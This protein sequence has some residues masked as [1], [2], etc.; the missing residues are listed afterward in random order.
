MCKLRVFTENHQRYHLIAWQHRSRLLSEV[1]NKLWPGQVSKLE[2][3]RITHHKLMGTHRFLAVEHPWDMILQPSDYIHQAQPGAY[4]K[5][6]DVFYKAGGELLILAEPGP[7]KTSVLQNLAH[8][9]V[10]IAEQE[11]DNTPM[12]STVPVVINLS[13]WTKKRKSIAIW[14]V[15]QLATEYHVPK[16]IG[17]MW[18]NNQQLLLLLDGL[19]EV[20]QKYRPECVKKLNNFHQHYGL[21]KMVICCR[22]VEYAAL[23]VRLKLQ[24]AITLP[25]SATSS[26]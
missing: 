23:P 16:S 2:S 17:R 20:R 21:M 6:I 25:S 4:A 10:V 18:V 1:K 26:Q 7:V 3:N 19:D 8:D 5:A 14:L 24:D 9:L 12:A 15:D 11:P 13:S 22:M